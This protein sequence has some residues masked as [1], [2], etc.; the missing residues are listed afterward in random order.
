[1]NNRK[2]FE[3][4][5]VPTMEEK[6]QEYKYLPEG[7]LYHIFVNLISGVMVSVVA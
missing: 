5:Y 1:V 6:Q 2:V 7:E 3:G 4:M